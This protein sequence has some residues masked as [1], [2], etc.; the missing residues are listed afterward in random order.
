[1]DI[2]GST[3]TA[4]IIK[5]IH[6]DGFGI[7]NGY[8]L[9]SLTNGVNIIMGNNEA[10]KSTLLKFLRYTLF[11]YPRLTDQR[12]PPLNGGR[13]GGRIKAMLI[14]GDEALFERFGNDKISLH[15]Q[16]NESQNPA[17][18]FQLLGNATGDLYN[19]VYA[20]SLDELV[21]MKSLGD[22]GV[23]DKIFSIGLGLGNISI[24][25]VE[26][27]IQD[28][29]EQIYKSRGKTQRIPGILNDLRER[30]S[31]IRAVQDQLPAFEILSN[32]QCSLK[33]GIRWLQEQLTSKREERARVE[34]YIKCYDAWIT[35]IRAGEA[36]KV[37]PHYTGYPDDA[38]VKL[39]RLEERE[40]EY[41]DELEKLRSGY[42]DETGIGDLEAMVEGISYN[43]DLISRKDEVMYLESQVSR[44]EQTVNDALEEQRLSDSLTA[45][46][47]R[48]ISSISRE[49]TEETVAGFNDLSMH[50]DRIERFRQELQQL[51]REK[52]DAEAEIR[53]SRAREGVVQ[54]NRI[55]MIISIALVI[56][57]LPAFYEGLTVVGIAL[58]A[59]ALLF[60]IGKRYIIRTDY[61]N[62]LQARIKNLEEKEME[63]QRIY[64]EYLEK[65]LNLPV[66]FSPELIWDVFQRID[67]INKDIHARSQLIKKIETSRKPFIK[68]FERRV[69][70]L[71]G[72]LSDNDVLENIH[73]TMH[74]LIAE[75]KS[76]QEKSALKT[77]LSE[78][79]NRKKSLFREVQRKLDMVQGEIE[80]LMQSV[81][82]AN[83]DEFRLKLEENNRV[84]ALMERRE[85][86]QEL[87]EQIAGRGQLMEVYEY[88]GLHDKFSI[89]QDISMLDADI[90]ESA[91][92]LQSLNKRLGEVENEL[93]RIEGES[94]LSELLTAQETARNQLY[95]EYKEWVAG[96]VAL[97]VLSTVRSA[98]EKEKQP[99]VLR[100]ASKYLR[101][102]TGGQYSS[103]RTSLDSHQVSVFTPQEASK[104]IGQLSRGTREQLL[105]SLRLGFIEEYEKQSEPLPV[106]VDEVFVNFDPERAK[107]TADILKEFAQ[108][109][110]V[111]VFTCRPETVDYF[112]GEHMI[113]LE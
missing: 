12:M 61:L 8:S 102:I 66:T 43:Q 39:D 67:Q 62:S 63:L 105:I 98:Y 53:A 49:W 5:D 23:A 24:G 18:W 70:D 3:D 59:L 113:A 13:H 92:K 72:L 35:A 54:V 101:Q 64:G 42:K 10:G 85:A 108:S 1:M 32:E 45:S 58:L 52:T 68:D 106:I 96:Q 77:R 27:T 47:D 57:S 100:L 28:R 41:A 103:I 74:S 88:L 93:R 17:Q 22:S 48:D 51:G 55:V 56:G 80:S 82:A 76:S 86:A 112:S 104:T 36:L 21:D 20:F 4:M 109:R 34:N 44:Y 15:Y 31:N 50:R 71:S 40:Q 6:I 14:S 9:S 87:I 97:E 79:L 26:R 84:K 33:D 73:M 111:L 95:L 65:E 110:Q 11:G 7:F 78:E 30:Q 2:D 60:F 25:D 38:L 69:N 16:G 89:E 81:G 107:Q 19:N 75:F 90:Q 83:R 94:D 46:I 91:E 29:L 37:L 99:E